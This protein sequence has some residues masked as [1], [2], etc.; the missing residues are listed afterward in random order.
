MR[1]PKKLSKERLS[2]LSDEDKKIYESEWSEVRTSLDDI[3]DEKSLNES[4][5]TTS[6]GEVS[7]DIKFALEELDYMFRTDLYGLMSEEEYQKFKEDFIAEQSVISLESDSDLQYNHN[8]LQEI[9]QPG[10]D[11]TAWL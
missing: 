6:T 4:T 9:G 10:H 3:F 1:F 2:L 5:V 8:K 11:Q 7:Q